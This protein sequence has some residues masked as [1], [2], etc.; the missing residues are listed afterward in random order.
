[1]PKRWHDPCLPLSCLTMPNQP[2]KNQQVGTA[3]ACSSTPVPDS[4]HPYIKKNSFSSFILQHKHLSS[5]KLLSQTSTTKNLQT[6]ISSSN[7]HQITKF[8][9]PNNSKHHSMKSQKLGTARSTSHTAV[10]TPRSLFCC[11]LLFGQATYQFISDLKARGFLWNILV[12]Y[13]LG[14]KSL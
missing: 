11:L 3:R 4:Q 2:P 14:L 6:F 9:H 12:M 7:L 13:F 8:L 5:L 10:P 1:M